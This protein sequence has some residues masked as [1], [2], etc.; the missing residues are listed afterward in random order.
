MRISE[1]EQFS[2]VPKNILIF[3][4]GTGQAGGLLPDQCLSNVYKLYRVTRVAP[5]NTIDPDEQVAFYDA[6]LGTDVDAA[7]VPLR[8]VRRVRK[9]AS[10]ATGTG[11]GRNIVDCYEAV[12]K[13]Y[14]PGDRIYLLGF[15]RGAYTA[16]A[17]A[18]VIGLCGIPTR[19]PNGDPLPKGGSA[20]RAIAS[21]AVHKVYQHG[22]GRDRRKFA[23]ERKELAK[24]F[25]A[26]YGSGAKQ[27][28]VVPYFVGVFD[29]VA[30]LGATGLRRWALNAALVLG[31][32]AAIYVASLAIGWLLDLPRWTVFAWAAAIA[33]LLAA[34]WIAKARLKVIW[35]YPEAGKFRWHWSGWRFKFY[36]TYL[37]PRVPFARHALAIDE[38]RSDFDRVRWG[39]RKG[40]RKRQPNEPEPFVQLWFAGNHSDIGGSYPEDESRLSDIALS[41]M[42][43][44]ATALPHPIMIDRARLQLFPRA[45]G[46]QHSEV[47]TF[48]DRYPRWVPRWLS[49]GWKE[50]VRDIPNGATVHPTVDQRFAL[51]TVQQCNRIA[52]YRPEALRNDN[53]YRH[54]Y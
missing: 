37:N 47:E 41:W 42:I 12:L 38:T 21:E 44:E 34:F 39:Q 25:R 43:S 33:T 13:Y 5:D 16:R 1:Y 52:P 20:L 50:K 27:A 11:L 23:P 19:L 49:R 24:R 10:A 8:L 7:S 29:T 3:S 46:M 30:A 53:R 18:G 14:E 15:S 51:P 40:N 6:G 4:D 35:D 31:V 45:T 17:V 36:D 28:N 22:S 48:V 26:K 32:A 9:I 2:A 54:L